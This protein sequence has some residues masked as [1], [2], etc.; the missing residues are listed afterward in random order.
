[1]TEPQTWT[2]TTPWD[3]KYGGPQSLRRDEHVCLDDGTDGFVDR[4]EITKNEVRVYVVQRKL[5]QS[6]L[7][8]AVYWPA[9]IVG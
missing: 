2:W 7:P 3:D 8:P 4:V 9:N 1:M 5:Q 6:N